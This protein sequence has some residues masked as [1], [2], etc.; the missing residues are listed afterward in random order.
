MISKTIGFRG[1]LFSDK[2]IWNGWWQ[3]VWRL[4]G[5]SAPESIWS[6]AAVRSGLYLPL[7]A[8]EGG[9]RG[10]KRWGDNNHDGSMVGVQLLATLTEPRPW[11]WVCLKMLCTPLYPLVLL[12]I[13]PIWKMAISL[14]IFGNIKPT[15]SDKANWREFFKR[16]PVVTWMT[17][18]R[19]LTLHQMATP[20][21]KAAGWLPVLQLIPWCFWPLW[22]SQKC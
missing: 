1:T 18:I 8:N 3:R 22:F 16:W 7:R 10:T 6:A 20:K 12:I 14:G 9:T 15:F 21:E 17:W 2:P 4:C 13:I 11:N 5:A 19:C